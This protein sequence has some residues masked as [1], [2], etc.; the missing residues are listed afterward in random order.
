MSRTTSANS[1]P[2]WGPRAEWNRLDPVRH[3]EC[4]PERRTGFS[5]SITT[6]AAFMNREVAT[7]TSLLCA[8]NSSSLASPQMEKQTISQNLQRAPQRRLAAGPEAGPSGGINADRDRAI[9][10]EVRVE[11]PLHHTAAGLALEERRSRRECSRTKSGKSFLKYLTPMTLGSR[12]HGSSCDA[13]LLWRTSCAE[14]ECDRLKPVLLSGGLRGRRSAEVALR[15]FVA[16]SPYGSAHLS[17]AKTPMLL[18]IPPI[19]ARQQ[20][21]LLVGQPPQPFFRSQVLPSL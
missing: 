11:P 1:P 21:E 15:G 4:P 5:L 10:L 9:D 6:G 3:E 2:P 17:R 7:A 18:D 20:R 14:Q 16:P 19:P 12:A 13:C 8:S